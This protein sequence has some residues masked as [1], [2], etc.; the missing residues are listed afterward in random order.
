M[1]IK[2]LPD[3]EF[4]KDFYVRLSIT[5][6]DMERFTRQNAFAMMVANDKPMV[7]MIR[8]FENVEHTSLNS[9]QT[10]KNY[11]AKPFSA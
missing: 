10:K 7:G 6:S 9:K 11:K 1:F 5:L 2:K 4:G 3:G 8:D